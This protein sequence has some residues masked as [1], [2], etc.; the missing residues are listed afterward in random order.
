MISI[1][2]LSNIPSEGPADPRLKELAP[3]AVGLEVTHKPNP[4]RAH[5]G[6]RSGCKYTWLF[7]TTV[8]SAAGAVT[9]NEFGVFS[10]VDSKWVFANYTGKPFAREHFADWYSCPNA[11]VTPGQEYS[12]PTNWGGNEVLQ[13]GRMKW[14]F[15]GTDEN[16]NRVKGEAVIEELAELD[17]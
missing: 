7:E 14:Y 5:R 12:D 16:G 3:L 13:E 11:T 8:R 17:A 15:I 1:G 6:G 2:P 10:W 4:V 9:I